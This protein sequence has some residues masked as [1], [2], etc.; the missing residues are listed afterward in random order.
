[1]EEMLAKEE[2]EEAETL[3]CIMVH[4]ELELDFVLG[5]WLTSDNKCSMVLWQAR[6]SLRAL[7]WENPQSLINNLWQ[8]P[9]KGMKEA[10][11]LCLQEPD[12]GLPH[13]KPPAGS[14]LSALG[15]FFPIR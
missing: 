13:K 11:V 5:N 10:V 8:L 3:H 1:M 12:T 15:A 2:Q 7:A 14:S 6:T 4:K 9:S